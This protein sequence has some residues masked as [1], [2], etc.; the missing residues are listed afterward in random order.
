MNKHMHVCILLYFWVGC[1]LKGSYLKVAPDSYLCLMQI[2]GRPAR[3]M[4]TRL[5]ELGLW[6]NASMCGAVASERRGASPGKSKSKL[7]K[8]SIVSITNTLAIFAE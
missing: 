2:E 3:H 5:E 8:E 4:V 7:L 6:R 1:Q